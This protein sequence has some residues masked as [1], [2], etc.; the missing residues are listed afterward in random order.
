MLKKVIE[1]DT[2]GP[3]GLYLGC[4]QEKVT[5]TTDGGTTIH[6]MNYN[7]EAFLEQCL[8]KYRTTA[9]SSEPK[10]AKVPFWHGPECRGPTREA[11]PDGPSPDCR[12]ATTAMLSA[13]VL[14]LTPPDDDDLLMATIDFL[15]DSDD[16]DAQAMTSWYTP[17][18]DNGES[19]TP[20]PSN[21]GTNDNGMK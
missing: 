13:Q 6:C 4:E 20:D 11:T 1:M 2:P 8:E 14:P 12:T 10:T 5:S 9:G 21:I 18:L 3:A 15:P 17:P 16:D 19:V 7:M